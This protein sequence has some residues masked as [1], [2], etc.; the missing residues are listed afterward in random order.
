[1]KTIEVK[2]LIPHLFEQSIKNEVNQ[3]ATDQILVGLVGVGLSHEH[4]TDE[5]HWFYITEYLNE[6]IIHVEDA[7]GLEACDYTAEELSQKLAGD[8]TTR[9]VSLLEDALQL[10]HKG[11]L[12]LPP[13]AAF[14]TSVDE[15]LVECP[16]GCQL[17]ELYCVVYSWKKHAGTD[18]DIMH[19]QAAE[20]IL[21]QALA[22]PL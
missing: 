7:E 16:P 4:D 6:I 2:K 1:M 17:N 19:V 18:Y 14:G 22:V 9:F 11:S 21:R 20:S 8:L 15:V 13:F 12:R 10:V 3:D 5:D